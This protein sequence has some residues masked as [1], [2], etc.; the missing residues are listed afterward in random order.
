M[1][2]DFSIRG[3]I[4][5]VTGASKGIG[6]GL[7]KSIAAAGAIVAV[8]ARDKASLAPLLEEIAQAGGQA[9][10]YELDV[11]SVVQIRTVFEQ[12]AAD[13]GRLDIVVNNAGVGDG[14]PAEEVTEEYW[15]EM[16]DVNL[17]GVFFCCQAAG[18]LMLAQGYGKIVNVSSQVSIVGIPEGVAYCASK[19]GVNQLTKVLALEWSSRGVC[20]NAVGPTFIYT[21]GTAERLDTPEFRRDVLARIP[22]GR[23]GTIDDV[24]GA[25]IYLASPASDLVTGTL[26]L[27]DGGWTAQ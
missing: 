13:F 17:K 12:V 9:A 10:A 18:R 8:T 3:K 24:A 22:A 25:V 15:D 23:I 5:I 26:L 16:I 1:Q 2:P 7:A 11:R 4:A 14:M 27:V 21:P 20:I 6:Y 19:G